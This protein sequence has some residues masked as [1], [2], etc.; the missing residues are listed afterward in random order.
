ME[1][2]NC[3]KC[4]QALQITPEL[5]GITV[6][7]PKCAHQFAVPKAAVETTTALKPAATLP[8]EPPPEAGAPPPPQPPPPAGT[9]GSRPLAPGAVAALVF[10]I[11]GLCICGLVFGLLAVSKG[12]QARDLCWENP[13]EYSGEGLALTGIILG[14]TGFA[15]TLIVLIVRMIM[16]ARGM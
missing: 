12:K 11:L 2:M 7:C 1:V 5:R 15:L 3:P 9:Q 8:P 14:W 10:A 4:G 16:L 13:G 6:Q